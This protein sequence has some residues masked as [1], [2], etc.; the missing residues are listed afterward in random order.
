ME[1]KTCEDYV[2]KRI[3]ELEKQNETLRNNIEELAS[4]VK[5]YGEI[6]TDIQAILEEHAELCTSEFTGR[7]I[8]FSSVYEK[9]HGK[10]NHF[11]KVL[12]ELADIKVKEQ[13]E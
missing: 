3:K 6:V 1:I 11:F 7:F 10:D 9:E 4:E 5:H 2:L 8:Y 13:E 12:T